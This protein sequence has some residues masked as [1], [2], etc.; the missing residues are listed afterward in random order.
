MTTIGNIA[1]KLLFAFIQAA[2]ILL[3]N[4]KDS[5]GTE[6][7]MPRL[8]SLIPEAE[9]G[10]PNS[11]EITNICASMLVVMTLSLLR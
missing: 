10:G 4:L 2:D 3:K 11:P 7:L 6:T 9:V 8:L 5:D 1:K